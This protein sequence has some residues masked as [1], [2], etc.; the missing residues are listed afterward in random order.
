MTSYTP[1]NSV[2][3]TL[4]VLKILNR[5]RV[6]SVDHI[7]RV[8]GLPKPTIVRLLETLIAAGYVSKEERDKGYRITSQVTALSCGFHG[9]PLAVETGRPWAKELTRVHRWPVAIAVPDGNAV[10]VCDTTCRDSPMAPYHA[11]IYKR[12]GLVT[13]ALGLAYLAF[14][15]AEERR[16]TMRLLETSS[17]PDSKIMQSP[18]MVEQL[19]RTA[20]QTQFA[21]RSGSMTSDAS[22]SV[23]VPIYEYGKSNILAT[24]GM[25]YYTSA[26]RRDDVIE[27]YVPHLQMASAAISESVVRMKRAL[28]AEKAAWSEEGKDCPKA[29]RAQKSV[30]ERV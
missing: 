18:G 14:C 21:E 10:V 6:S 22:S 11:L 8:T 1:V 28:E 29:A 9:A 27:R 4:E 23:A 24:I 2:L 16:L 19:I 12:L 5:Q 26:V 17:H 13:M 30:T 7:H 25:T 20:Q 15:P 3:R